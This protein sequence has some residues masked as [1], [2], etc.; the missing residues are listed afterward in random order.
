MLELT[1]TVVTI[2]LLHYLITNFRKRRANY[3]ELLVSNQIERHD[4]PK[5]IPIIRAL[6]GRGQ[7]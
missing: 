5:L 2:L 6:I 3:K 7:S 1:V 4:K